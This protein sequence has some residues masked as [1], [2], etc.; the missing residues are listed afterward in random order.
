M[1]A[2]DITVN[3]GIGYSDLGPNILGS[4]G[5]AF[6]EWEYSTTTTALN[7][8]ATSAD[9]R[10]AYA[11]LQPGSTYT[12]VINHTSDSPYG[13]NSATPYVDTM[14]RVGISLANARA[15]GLYAAHDGTLDASISFS[16]RY[17]F[18]FNRSDGIAPGY[19][20]F[21]GAAAHEMGHALGFISGVDDIDYYMGA[22][23][24]GT[25]SSNLM[26]LFRYSQVSLA[27]GTGYTD[28][29]ADNRDKYFSVDGGVTLIAYFANGINYGDGQQASHWRDN[30]G[31]GIMDPTAAPGEQ[32]AIS[33]TDLRMM[34]VLG[35]TPVSVPEP[36]S[37]ALLGMGAVFLIWRGGR[38]LKVPPA[39]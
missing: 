38:P 37:T 4:T 6:G 36:A 11:A 2:N 13:A 21:V 25:F 19:F 27:A 23:P 39:C 31:I 29:T 5:S 28:Y 26:D 20:D 15:L 35:Y 14:N 9:D 10:S 34:D 33:S 17:A 32:L 24:G 12:R 16:S 8:S 1:L 7:A 22:Y 3:V 18:D 30:L